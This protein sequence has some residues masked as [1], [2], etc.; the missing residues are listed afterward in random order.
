MTRDLLVEIVAQVATAY[1][2]NFHTGEEHLINSSVRN[3]PAAW[4]TPPVVCA[5]TGRREGEITW[6]LTLHFMALPDAGVPAEN[7][8]RGLERDAIETVKG[9]AEFPEV[10][11]V[12]NVRCTPADRSLTVHGERSVALTCDVTMWYIN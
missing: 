3:Y 2:Y 6:R 10:C 12:E 5:R 11:A 8:W 4:L 9:V 1:G 7:T